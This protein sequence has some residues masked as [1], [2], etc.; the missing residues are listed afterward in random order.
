MDLN[1]LTDRGFSD[2]EEI[3]RQAQYNFR[4]NLLSEVVARMGA[5]PI[6]S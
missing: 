2:T 4:Y 5:T 3:F 1:R 6:W